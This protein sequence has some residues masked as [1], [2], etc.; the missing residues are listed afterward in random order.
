MASETTTRERYGDFNVEV[1]DHNL[2]LNLP[3]RM[4]K[5]VIVF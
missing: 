5:H 1:S 4:G 3:Q 2:G